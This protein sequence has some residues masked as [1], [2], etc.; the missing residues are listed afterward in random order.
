MKE[1]RA[2][3]LLLLQCVG[4]LSAFLKCLGC[5]KLVSAYIYSH[6]YLFFDK[7]FMRACQSGFIRFNGIWGFFWVG[8]GGVGC[9]RSRSA[10]L[11]LSPPCAVVPAIYISAFIHKLYGRFCIFNLSN[12]QPRFNCCLSV[13]ILCFIHY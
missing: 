5:L 8:W 9:V 1:I 4:Y 13:L 11:Q 10:S 3:L 2:V 6:I 7:C 12:K